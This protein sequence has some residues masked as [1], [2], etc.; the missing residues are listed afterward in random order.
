MIIA[1]KIVVSGWYGFKNTGDEAILS[2]MISTLKNELKNIEIVVFSSDPIYTSKTHNVKSVKMHSVGIVSGISLLL[3][4]MLY[5][6]MK[7]LLEA[8]LFILGGGGF[9]SDWQS[10][11]VIKQWLGQVVLAKMFRKKVMLYAIG[12]GP[13]TTVKGKYLT[14]TILN[15]CT[16]V[17]TVRDE[18]SKKWLKKAGVKKEIYVTADPA[19]QLDPAES[20]RISEILKEENIDSNKPLVGIALAPI[21]HIQKYWP[22]QQNKYYKFKEV[23]PEIIDI[24]TLK[25]D[26]DVVFIPM[27]IPTDRDFALELTKKMENNDRIKVIIG[28]YTPQE[29]MGIIGRLD[30]I[31]GMRLHSLILASV[32]CVPMVGIVYHHKLWSFLSK[33]GFEK[34]SVGLGD[35]TN[36]KNEDI[37]PNEMSEIITK[38][39]AK[40]GEIKKELEKNKNDL[41]EQEYTNIKLLLN[42]L[43]D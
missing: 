34:M 28:E 38:V 30:M 29:V 20:D 32:M 7:P 17:I 21:F 43:K 31:I 42:I 5:Q 4:G 39:W 25:L 6:T 22:N 33:V 40:R 8:D 14:R 9:L 23:W 10:W 41:K 36:W 12:A 13:I 1:K 15:K 3:K 35:G 37:D 2:S 24:I 11:T 26:A 16:D 19:V 27:Q 18:E